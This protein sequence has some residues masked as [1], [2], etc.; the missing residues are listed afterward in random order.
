MSFVRV[1]R[2][3]RNMSQEQLANKAGLKRYKIVR[4]ENVD[5]IL[6]DMPYDDIKKIATA[7]DMTIDEFV[8]G[9]EESGEFV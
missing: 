6:K 3:K 5:N 2:A 7:F 4:S 1:E 9:Y 8:K